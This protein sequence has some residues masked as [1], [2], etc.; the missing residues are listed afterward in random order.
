MVVRGRLIFAL[1]AGASGV[2]ALVLM[3][4]VAPPAVAQTI[5]SD[6]GQNERVAEPQE[7]LRFSSE[8]LVGVESPGGGITVDLEGRFQHYL[9]AHEGA[10]G[11][12]HIGCTQDP[13]DGHTHAATGVEAGE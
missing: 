6:G 2:V 9:V 11:K 7:A 4:A 3:L 10:D 13:E 12:L 5:G 1:L 8:G